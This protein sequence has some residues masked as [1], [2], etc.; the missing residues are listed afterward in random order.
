MILLFD[1]R[2]E[3]LKVRGV[4]L[5]SLASATLSVRAGVHLAQAMA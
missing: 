3:A 2:R 4:M 5:F 1:A